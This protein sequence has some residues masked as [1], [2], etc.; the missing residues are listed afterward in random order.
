MPKRKKNKQT[1]YDLSK[2]A[3]IRSLG[4]VFIDE[5]KKKRK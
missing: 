1:Q 2:Q 5:K 3:A 4:I